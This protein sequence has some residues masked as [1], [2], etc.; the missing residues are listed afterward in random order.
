MLT[1][2][3]FGAVFNLPVG[4]YIAGLLGLILALL[5]IIVFPPDIDL[6]G[7]FYHREPF[8]S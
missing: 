6:Q 8:G 1:V 2:K 3:K 5:A 7:K 4:G